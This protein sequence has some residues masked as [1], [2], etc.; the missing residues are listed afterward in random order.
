MAAMA[1]EGLVKRARDVKGGDRGR[2]VRTN[3]IAE[4]YST[5][6]IVNPILGYPIHWHSCT[7]QVDLDFSS[8][9]QVSLS[10]NWYPGNLPDIRIMVDQSWNH[11]D[12]PTLEE[13]RC[14]KLTKVVHAKLLQPRPPQPVVI[15][16]RP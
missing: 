12:N 7:D 2:E 14:L 5:Q 6:D 9:L 16:I 3:A 13:E 4:S 1:L 10:K 11:A 8:E 15:S